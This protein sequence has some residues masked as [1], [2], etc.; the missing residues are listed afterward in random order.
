[1]NLLRFALAAGVDPKWVLNAG[2]VLRRKVH[3][4]EE[5]ARL[6]ALT[7]LLETEGGLPLG[8]AYGR[9]A[10][11]HAPQSG[12]AKWEVRVGDVSLAVDRLRF[13]TR[14]VLDLARARTPGLERQRGRPRARKGS[15]L[16]RAAAYGVDLSLLRASLRKSPAERLQR[17]DED[18]EFMHSLRVVP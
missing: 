8:V 13:M 15:A 1:M 16:A 12:D 2:A 11:L 14:F 10:R 18:L 5:Q 7:R 17:L 4:S 6:F 3:Y 9:A